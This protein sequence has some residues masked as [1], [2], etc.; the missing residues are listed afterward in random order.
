MDTVVPKQST[1]PGSAQ[2]VARGVAVVERGAARRHL[3]VANL[4]VLLIAAIRPVL[5]V[6]R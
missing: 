3:Y 1:N 2:P 4:K 6:M 5:P